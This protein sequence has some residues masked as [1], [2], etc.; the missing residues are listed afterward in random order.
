MSTL[1]GCGG[2]GA[3]DGPAASAS[4]FYPVGLA[5][6]QPSGD[7]Y[8]TDTSNHTVRMGGGWGWGWEVGGGEFLSLSLS[9]SFSSHSST[10]APSHLQVR[11]ICARTGLVSTLAGSAGQCG[12]VDGVGSEAR[13]NRPGGIAVDG[14]G[15]VYVSDCENHG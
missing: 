3:A 11:V 12:A 5:L 14:S 7:V 15:T 6:H 13:F 1:A 10:C 4:F 9:L 8:V 2:Q